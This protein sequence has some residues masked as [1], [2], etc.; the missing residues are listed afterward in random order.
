MATFGYARACRR[1]PTLDRQCEALAAAGVPEA[2]LVVEYGASMY[3]HPTLDALLERL[4]PGDT[5][6]VWALDRL[7]ADA[8]RI[9]RVVQDLDRRGLR[10]V[11]AGLGLDTAAPS[12]RLVL[13]AMAQLAPPD[14]GDDPP[15]GG[16]RAYGVRR[17]GAKWPYR[18]TPE[19][20][21]QVRRM[22]RE[23]KRLQAEV[24]AAF[25]V[26]P[27]TVWRA[28]NLVPPPAEP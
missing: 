28:V 22:V 21:E 20:I 16:I 1:I 25:G 12:G 13:A 9:A 10:L 14:P 15:D 26:S 3:L 27:S 24:A 7:G 23:E 18:L 8:T 19:Q 4:A 5:L 17:E 2:L 6:V 11:V